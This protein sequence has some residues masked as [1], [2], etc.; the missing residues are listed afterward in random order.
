MLN[1][2]VF[3]DKADKP[4]AKNPDKLYR[5]EFGSEGSTFLVTAY[6]GVASG[7]MSTVV[8]YS[9]PSKADA[10]LAYSDAV[11]KQLIAGYQGV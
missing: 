7:K 9:G 4:R 2:K 1:L 3:E 8:K 11:R 6:F 10:L 5:L